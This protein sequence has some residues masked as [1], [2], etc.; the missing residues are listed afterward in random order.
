MNKGDLVRYTRYALNE[1]HHRTSAIGLVIM[2]GTQSAYVL[3]ANR[4][5]PIWV[6]REYLETLNEN[7]KTG[8]QK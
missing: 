3:F 2:G 5:N 1:E 6:S 7:R 4:S 8:E